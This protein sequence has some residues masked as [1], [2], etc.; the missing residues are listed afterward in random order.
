M[1]AHTLY[2]CPDS[3]EGCHICDGGLALCTVCK[4]A[5]GSLPTECPGYA[6]DGSTQ[7]AVYAGDLDYQGGKWV[8][9]IRCWSCKVLTN[10]D[11]RLAA[12]GHCPSC[13]VEWEL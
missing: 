6:M 12:D 10:T 4:G 11:A 8:S 3:C 1:K 2:K 5:E 7:E 13:G 9:P